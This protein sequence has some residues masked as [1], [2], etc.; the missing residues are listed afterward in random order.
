MTTIEAL[1]PPREIPIATMEVRRLGPGDGQFA[2][3]TIEYTLSVHF[4]PQTGTKVTMRM[5]P[6]E[7]R[8]FAANVARLAAERP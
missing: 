2:E 5:G 6:D 7:A 8:A 1:P 4:G 3:G